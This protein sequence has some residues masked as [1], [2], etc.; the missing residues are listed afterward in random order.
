[1]HHMAPGICDCCDGSDE[2]RYPL[3][4]VD[5]CEEQNQKEYLAAS[6][7]HRI[8]GIGYRTRLL[9]L[10]E[11]NIS[12]A[13]REHEDRQLRTELARLEDLQLKVEYLSVRE[14]RKEQTMRVAAARKGRERAR[15]DRRI[16]AKKIRGELR[17]LPSIGESTEP[18]GDGG[19]QQVTNCKVKV[20]LVDGKTSE[21]SLLSFV[22]D[23]L[24]T[25]KKRK[26]SSRQHFEDTQTLKRRPVVTNAG[27][28]RLAER[29]RG[30]IRATNPRLEPTYLYT[31]P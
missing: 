27:K 13:K 14:D 11:A 1:M 31:I 6:E 3:L 12:A 18:D 21:V 15:G 17:R 25:R 23:Q 20:S 22:A 2:Y 26:P 24:G 28:D 8:A 9:W 30:I 5:I 10:R 19:L 16:T 4:C 29:R 7:R